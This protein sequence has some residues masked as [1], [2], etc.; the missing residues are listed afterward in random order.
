MAMKEGQ[1]LLLKGIRK[2]LFVIPI[3][4]IIMMFLLNPVFEWLIYH[5]GTQYMRSYGILI[6]DGFAFYYLAFG[7]VEVFL[8]RHILS[9]EKVLLLYYFPIIG[10]I[11][12]IIQIMYPLQ[13][14]T[15]FG[16]VLCLL[17]M[18]FTIQNYEA[19]SHTGYL[20]RVSFST[21]INMFYKRNEQFSIIAISIR[22]YSYLKR[23]FGQEVVHEA[24]KTAGY[25]LEAYVG[26]NNLIYYIGTGRYILVY[27]QK[28]IKTDLAKEI[29]SAFDK[30]ITAFNTKI[31]LDIRQCIINC[32]TDI[33]SGKTC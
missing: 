12:V 20:N 28:T 7:I 17:L 22:G 29:N 32:P 13:L 2:Y 18:Y 24:A 31:K 4:L 26:R 5:D 33:D 25:R 23:I 8:V 14:V 16:I 19:I 1:G 11:S 9:K 21:L 30:D 3:A 27:P 15:M 6:L 10:T